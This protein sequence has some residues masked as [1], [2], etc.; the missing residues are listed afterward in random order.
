[1]HLHQYMTWCTTQL[2]FTTSA[3][4]PT[5]DNIYLPS[6]K[7][8]EQEHMPGRRSYGLSDKELAFRRLVKEAQKYDGPRERPP[9]VPTKNPSRSS[10]RSSMKPASLLTVEKPSSCTC[11]AGYSLCAICPARAQSH[12]ASSYQPRYSSL[13]PQDSGSRR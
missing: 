6:E 9:P 12:R 5:R 3:A 7:L 11:M 8:K 13:H 4:M 1:M 10:K 2:L